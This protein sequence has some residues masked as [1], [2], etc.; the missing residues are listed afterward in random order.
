MLAIAPLHTDTRKDVALRS[1]Q[2]MADGTLEDFVEIVH[3][4]FFN[5]EQRDEP[6]QTRGPG[7]ARTYGVARWLRD[8]FADLRWDVH[9]AIAQDD[10]V[11]VRCT[12]SGRHT[13]DMATYDLDGRVAEV[14]APTGATFATTQSHWLR[15]CDDQAI[16]HWANRDDL[17][18]ARQLGWAPPTP[19]YLLR[20]ALAK[21]RARR[22][23]AP[24]R[25]AEVRPLQPWAGD[26][27]EQTIAALRVVEAM[28][29]V[30]DE[31]FTGFGNP[32]RVLDE[33]FADLDIVVHHVVHEGGLT[34]V[35]LTVSGRQVGPVAAYDDAGFVASVFP[36]TGRRFAV[37]HTHWMRLAGDG[38]VEAHWSD[39]DD[40][41]MAMQ[42]GWIPPTPSYLV[43][44]ALARR[45]LSRP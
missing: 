30:P 34:A 41:G 29:R 9:E 13:G 35:H 25:P 22:A 31:L 26:F 28:R 32:A 11:V 7:A 33:S 44:M 1:I 15:I 8:A 39:R 6:P 43:R 2:I 16:E 12:M 40:L 24:P 42:L 36:P 10:L 3:P 5:H 38:T 17:G 14:F 18:T 21:R 27:D 23:A 45:R 20:C 37:T 4:E 19:A